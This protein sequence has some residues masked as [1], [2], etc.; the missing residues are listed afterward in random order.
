MEDHLKLR[1]RFIMVSVKKLGWGVYQIY[2]VHGFCL[3]VEKGG[4]PD[5]TSTWFLFRS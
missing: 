3:G 5:I 2:L 4:L 1:L